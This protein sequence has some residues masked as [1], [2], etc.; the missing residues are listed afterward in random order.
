MTEREKVRLI[1]CITASRSRLIAD[2]TCPAHSLI[3]P[4]PLSPDKREKKPEES[5]NKIVESCSEIEQEKDTEESK[6]S[7]EI[8]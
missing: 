4:H 7:V 5:V 3:S 6:P 8:E 1:D 2:F